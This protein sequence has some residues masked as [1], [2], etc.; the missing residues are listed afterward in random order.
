MHTLQAQP[1]KQNGTDNSI[2]V[3]DNT[4][5]NS[6]ISPSKY[7]DVKRNFSRQNSTGIDFGKIHINAPITIMPKLT[8]NQP[9]DIHERE[10][11]TVAEKVMSNP[12]THADKG[13]GFP[14]RSKSVEIQRKCA[15]CEEKEKKLQKKEAGNATTPA[16]DTVNQTLQIQRKCAECEEKEKKLQKKESGNSTTPAY[17]TVSQALQSPGQPLDTSTRNFMESRFRYDFS[18]VKIHTNSI[19]AESAREVNAHAYTVGNS[20]VF[21][22]GQYTPDTTAGRKLLAHELTHTIQ[23]APAGRSALQSKLNIGAINTP[24]ETEAEH[25]AE[26]VTNGA[27]NRVTQISALPVLRRQPIDSSNTSGTS[28]ADFTSEQKRGGQPRAAFVDAGKRGEDNVRIAITRYLCN[29]DLRNVTEKHANAQLQPDTGF[30]LEFCRGRVVATLDGTVKP[31]GLT[32]GDISVRGDINI[33][34]NN[35]GVGANIGVEGGVSNTGSEPQ[36]RG[37][38]DLRIGNDKVQGGLS[39]EITKGLDT[40]KIDTDVVAGVKVGKYEVGVD[41]KNIQD[42]NRQIIPVFQGNLPGQE[43][44]DK[45]CQEC[46]CPVVY[47]CREDIPPRDYEEPVTYEVSETTPLRYYFSLDTANDTTDPVLKAQSTQMLDEVARRVKAG[48]KIE[49]VMGYAS[50]EDNRD[51]PTPNEQLSMSRAKH[52]RDLLAPKLGANVQLPQPEPGGELL[53][54]TASILP[55]SGLAD[56]ITE[57]GFKGPE[58]VTNFLVGDD[59][60]N[61]Q[62]ADQFL[63]LLQNKKM[64]E[65][66]ARLSL[67]GIDAG[68]PAAPRL[69]TAIDRFIA[70]KGKGRRPWENI[71]GYLRFATV[72]LV[73]THPETHMEKKSTSG[74]LSPTLMDDAKCKPYAQQAEANGGFGPHEPKPKDKASCRDRSGNNGSIGQK[75]AYN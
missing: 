28:E 5:K 71:F 24:E 17:D 36:I 8:V 64:Q 40:G 15:K 51:R 72:K 67:F 4:L 3:A 49:S 50:P 68:S 56:A 34:P 31:S 6:N 11:D 16:Y 59:I 42:K 19:A 73:E 48:A 39:G 14:F 47:E 74:S 1:S 37:K 70:S 65:P 33:A 29:C 55:G 27:A 25:V 20:V 53:G 43:I 60:T 61:A 9:N 52:L 54:R 2:K 58:E 23:Q 22:R 35:G 21:A 62:L 46:R 13:F 12:G 63:A 44:S 7:N 30:T 57:V 38:V 32:K 75:C 45:T 10:A 18:Q 66:A 69:L 41:V 26:Q